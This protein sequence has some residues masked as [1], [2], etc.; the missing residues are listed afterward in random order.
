[1]TKNE[2]CAAVEPDRAEIDALDEV[3][4]Q[5]NLVTRNV[6]IAVPCRAAADC[7]RSVES[8]RRAPQIAAQRYLHL[9]TNP[10]AIKGIEADNRTDG[11][12]Q[13]WTT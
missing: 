4:P 6:A 10:V 7:G 13:N 8:S 12:L 9:L 11:V 2:T 5:L 3:P 1:M